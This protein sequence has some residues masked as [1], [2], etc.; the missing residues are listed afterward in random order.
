VAS[1][2]SAC[3]DCLDALGPARRV[4]GQP[5]HPSGL[6]PVFCL[7]TWD[8]PARALVLAHKERARTGLARPLGEALAPAVHLVTG[9]GIGRVLLVPVPSR[10]GVRRARG[11]DPVARMSAAAAA[12]LRADGIH[13]LA[14]PLLR[15]ARTVADQAGLTASQRAA[16]LAGALT[17]RPGV[18][19]VG[20]ALVLVDDVLTTGA[21]LAEAARAL[22][23][24]GRTVAGAVVVAAVEHPRRAIPGVSAQ[25]RRRVALEVLSETDSPCPPERTRANVGGWHLPGSVVAPVQT[26]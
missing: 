25:A 7:A 21:T 1:P 2:T 15:H 12:A 18:S 23:A 11:H 16:N 20:A 3:P 17:V 5:I 14:V 19:A 9:A 8:G 4:L 10:S 22:R 24:S 6:P 13:A 26:G